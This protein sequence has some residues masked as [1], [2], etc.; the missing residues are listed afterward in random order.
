MQW[1]PS[2]IESIRKGL[3]LTQRQLAE[4]SGVSQSLI[5]K[6]ERGKVSPSFEVV[7]RIFDA[8]ERVR[9]ERSGEP[10]AKDICTREVISVSVDDTVAKAIELMRKHDISQMPVF[11]GD[12]PVGSISE[13]TIT[14]KLDRI[15]TLSVKVKDV[16]DEC[17][18]T[19]PEEASL[20]VVREILL[21]YPAVLV[22]RNGVVTGIVTKADI[23]KVFD[24]KE[25]FRQSSLRVAGHLNGGSLG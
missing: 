12:R 2:L 11:D 17:F 1:D 16:M 10:R 3:G 15:R 21:W 14:R 4:L 13:S 5:S 6:I 22:Q 7:R 24:L 25:R 20:T 8:F 18:P 23:L 19:V 9:A